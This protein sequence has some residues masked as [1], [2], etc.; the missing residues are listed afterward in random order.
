MWTFTKLK[1][2]TGRKVM[3]FFSKAIGSSMVDVKTNGQ[4]KLRVNTMPNQV[5]DIRIPRDNG[6]DQIVRSGNYCCL[7]V[8]ENKNSHR[9]ITMT[10]TQISCP[11]RI[12]LHVGK[13]RDA[14]C[15]G[16][17]PGP[18]AR[19]ISYKAQTKQELLKCKRTIQISTF[20]VRTLNRIG[21]QPELTASAIDHNIDIIYI[22]EHRYIHSKDIEYHDTGNGGTLVFASAW[23][24]SVNATIWAV[25]MCRNFSKELVI[26]FH[27][28]AAVTWGHVA[29]IIKRSATGVSPSF[30]STPTTVSNSSFS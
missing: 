7:S 6:L 18:S 21:Q 14:S 2:N 30:G 3:I 17:S 20:N 4:T 23:K 11:N 10:H 8:D 16:W 26:L 25:G 29:S 19:Q 12:A 5:L 15:W 1:F 24:N 28:T 27:R 9:K 13:K 22:Q